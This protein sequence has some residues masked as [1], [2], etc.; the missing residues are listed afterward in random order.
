MSR[1]IKRKGDEGQRGKERWRTE[2]GQREKKDKRK[3]QGQKEM[4]T[5]MSFTF[6]T[7]DWILPKNI[8]MAQICLSFFCL[9][10]FSDLKL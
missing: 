6:I 4:E 8:F 9:K 2:G 3:R 10:V 7:P 5:R 1:V